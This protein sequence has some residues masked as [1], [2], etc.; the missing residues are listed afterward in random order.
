M[1]SAKSNR[2]ARYLIIIGVIAF[3]LIGA[4]VV[5]AKRSNSVQDF[6]TAYYRGTCLVQHCD[7]YS[8][9][10]MEA[11]YR[12]AGEPPFTSDQER[13]VATRNIY[14]PGEFP[15]LI[16]L[17][18][19]PMDLGRALW[20]LLIAGSFILACFL[21]W[22]RGARYAPLLSAVL[23][24]F[25][26]LN[27]PTLFY[28]GN[29][30]S[31]LVPFAIIAVWCFLENRF[32]WVGVVCLAVSLIL[33]PHNAA[34]IWILLILFSAGSRRQATRT[35][36]LIALISIPATAWVFHISPGWM[37]EFS[38][39]LQVL[40]G[41]GGASDPST[42]HGTCGLINLQ[43][44]TSL[45]WETPGAY[46]LAT[47]LICAPMFLYWALLTLK[48]GGP[49][50]VWYALATIAPLSLLPVYH[51][52]YDAKLLLLLVPACA[53]LWSRGKVLAWVALGITACAFIVTGDAF[54]IALFGLMHHL[55]PDAGAHYSRLQSAVL[56][57]PVPLTLLATAIFY[58]WVYARETSVRETTQTQPV[59]PGERVH[60]VS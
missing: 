20:I 49:A 22:E 19:L 35:L 2:D 18:V 51:R 44:V 13:L 25:C 33:K 34:F 46:N 57:C 40:N 28:F 38:A 6:T 27:S 58:L 5:A 26:L 37:H 24:S 52:Q 30:A 59:E 43:A 42:P 29:P 21:M 4:A 11:L 47:Y 12:R 10:D 41:Q 8:G 60:S 31:F 9:A 15:F 39:N 50:R 7:P 55:Y 16:P 17:A 14:L 3:L 54:G 45:M 36:L 56:D 23:V 32:I 48:P 53:L 1:E